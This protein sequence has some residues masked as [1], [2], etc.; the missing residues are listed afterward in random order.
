MHLLFHCAIL[1]FLWPFMTFVVIVILSVIYQ[2]NK[3]KSR[4]HICTKIQYRVVIVGNL[5]L[6]KLPNWIVFIGHASI[7]WMS[8]FLKIMTHEK[9]TDEKKDFL[10]WCLDTNIFLKYTTRFPAHQ[11]TSKCNCVLYVCIFYRH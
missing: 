2:Y 10:F 6:S 11:I 4:T 7:S 8:V 5:V 9:Q 3:Y 1:A